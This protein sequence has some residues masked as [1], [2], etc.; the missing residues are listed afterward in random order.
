M[1]RHKQRLGVIGTLVWDV[2]HGWPPGSASSEGWGGIAYALS[3]LAAGL[4]GNW[5]VV[6]IL[7]V[8]QDVAGRAE[9]LLSTLRNVATDAAPVIVPEPNNR[10]EIHY[11]SE[12]ERTEL[13]SGR[14]PEWEWAELEPRLRAGNLDALYV[15]FVSGWELDLDAARRMRAM[16]RGPIYADLHMMLWVPQ[17]NGL[18]A[19]QPLP[20]A[21]EWLG[22]FDFVQVNE[23]EMA[24]LAGSFEE[25]AA[26]AFSAG[27]L[28]TVITLGSRGAIC[29]APR[30]LDLANIS[31][32]REHRVTMESACSELVAPRAVRSGAGVD[33]TGCGD[34]WG[35]T[36]FTRLLLGDAPAAAMNA[37][38][39]AAGRN[40]SW[41]GVT[42]LV[43]HLLDSRIG[44][45]R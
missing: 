10:S 14:T 27:V 9:E 42:G 31:A 16:F 20:R 23:E 40:A 15:N 24:M 36:F 34:V 30:H 44:E 13:L 22:C 39:E 21:A 45:A 33:P 32:A 3:A 28:C 25:L 6:P 37:A 43:D 12:E 19:L 7:K 26:N 11:Y 8:G 1:V 29:F 35:A 41:R 2:I 38:H 5:E 18:R 17:A 4:P